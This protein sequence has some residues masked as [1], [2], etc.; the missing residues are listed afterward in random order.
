MELH[1]DFNP[2]DLK[3]P[4]Q[5]TVAQVDHNSPLAGAL[6]PE[7]DPNDPAIWD[8]YNAELK[9]L[10]SFWRRLAIGPLVLFFFSI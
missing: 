10:G 5:P 6:K 1:I 9:L 7:V 3:Q 2:F 8:Q 4:T